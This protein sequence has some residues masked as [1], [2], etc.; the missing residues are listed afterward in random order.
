MKNEVKPEQKLST[1]LD[2]ITVELTDG[3]KE[4]ERNQRAAVFDAFA[5]YT[6]SR[7]H[8]GQALAAYKRA[9]K[10]ERIWL[11]ASEAIAKHMHVSPRTLFRIVSDYERVSGV[12]GTVISA[13]EAEGFDPAKRKHAPLLEQITEAIGDD[14]NPTQEEAQDIVQQSVS[15]TKQQ[16]G[17]DTMSEDERIVRGLRQGI[18]RWL[19]NVPDTDRK[20][21]LLEQSIAEESFEVWGDQDP[22]GLDIIPRPGARKL[23]DQQSQA[24]EMAA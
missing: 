10:M 19:R 24:L 7:F 17:K 2:S 8:L 6:K 5:R 14:P 1:E 15:S 13:M 12:S 20:C 16:K 4:Q 22:W 18:R 11:P 23:D 9:C 21:D 3:D